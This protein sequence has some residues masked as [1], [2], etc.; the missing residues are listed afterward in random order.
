MASPNV[1]LFNPFELT[2]PIS[3]ADKNSDK[4]FWRTFV[5]LNKDKTQNAIVD[6]GTNFITGPN[7]QVKALMGKLEGV[8]VEQSPGGS[9]QGCYSCNNNPQQPSQLKLHRHR[10]DLQ[11]LQRCYHFWLRR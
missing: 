4:T 7:D 5:E 9:Y 3:W 6:S 10:S 11:A 8:S 2:G 1:D